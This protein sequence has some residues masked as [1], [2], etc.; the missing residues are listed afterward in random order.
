MRKIIILLQLYLFMLAPNVFANYGESCSPLPM[1]ITDNY[2]QQN[3]AYGYLLNNIDIKTSAKGCE[4][5]DT[6]LKFC[7]RNPNKSKPDCIL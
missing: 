6:T 1:N 2:L 3:T 7:L 5:D 4:I